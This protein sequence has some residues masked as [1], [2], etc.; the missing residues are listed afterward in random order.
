MSESEKNTKVLIVDDDKALAFIIGEMLEDEGHVV[1][2]ASDGEDGYW[3]Y[4]IFRPDLVITDIQ[5]PEKDGLELMKHIR[6]HNPE[7]RTIYMSGDLKRFRSLL[8]EEK[9]RYQ[10][11]LLGKPFSKVEL[12]RM[13]SEHF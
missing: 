3:T 4:L 2:T 6:V 13:V 5:M 11:S 10:V 9:K 8:E 1:K 12:I 7:I